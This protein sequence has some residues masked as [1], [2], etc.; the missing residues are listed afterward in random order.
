M[1]RS[2]KES[3][4]ADIKSDL[5][6]KS[7][8]IL[9]Q[10]HGVTVAQSTQLRRDMLGV[11]AKLRVV[12]NTLLSIAIDG[13]PLDGLKGMLKGP[14]IVAYSKDPV[15]A[16]KVLSKFSDDN[17]GNLQIVGGWMNGTILDSKG[18]HV[19]AK[20]PSLDE[21]RAKII[22]LL[23]AP[24]TKLVRTIK[25]PMSRVARVVSMKS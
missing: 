12:K 15:S 17:E 23:S 21:L 18:I 13:T 11:G 1:D 6:E 9:A 8:V 5:S 7:L 20:L 19:L 4:I 24:A 16:A 22:G 3:L 25:E 2:Q 10:Q 14:V